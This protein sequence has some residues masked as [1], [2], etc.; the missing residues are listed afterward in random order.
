MS[1]SQEIPE[2]ELK[3]LFPETEA[4][5]GLISATEGKSESVRGEQHLQAALAVGPSCAGMLTHS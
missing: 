1:C 2:L 3:E 4:A 5:C